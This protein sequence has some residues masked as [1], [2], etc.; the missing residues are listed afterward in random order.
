MFAEVVKFRLPLIAATVPPLLVVFL[1]AFNGLN[2]R[3]SVGV[4][5]HSATATVSVEQMRESLARDRQLL[6]DYEKA[7][8]ALRSEVIR[9]RK[10]LE[11]G[12]ASKE[13]VIEIEKSFIAALKRVHE[14]RY[15]VTET[16]IAITEAVLGE[17]VLRMP[18]L[19]VGGFSETAELLRFNGAFKWSIREAPR[20]EKYF[21]Q[22]FGRNL[23]I[24]AR[25]QSDTHN[26]LGFDHR[27]SVDVGL[28]PDSSE[29]KSLIDYLRKS[30]IPFLAF[31]QAVPGAATGPHI[32]IGKPSN[33]LSS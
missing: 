31:R 1:F 32:H 20:V 30:G 8:S 2:R 12:Q 22:T 18:V 4:N 3:A 11:I 15:S 25:G 19:P 16:Q 10:S 5:D 26:R 27:D 13:Q 23:P 24:T 29:G 6:T 9:Q 14:M 28:H 7:Q 21:S 33:R 17:K